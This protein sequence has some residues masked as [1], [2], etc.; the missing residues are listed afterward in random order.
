LITGRRLEDLLTV[1][2]QLDLFDCVVAENG[3]V[4][5]EPATRKETSLAKPAPPQFVQ[6]LK[7]LRVEPLEVGRVIVS[8]WL[9]HHTA[10]LQVIQEMR[11]RRRLCANWRAVDRLSRLG[12]LCPAGNWK[13][14][15]QVAGWHDCCVTRT[16][17]SILHHSRDAS[18]DD[19]CFPYG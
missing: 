15:V 14:T 9:P 7:E 5:Y 2:P 10:V 11:T 13:F 1:F 18:N 19:V 8:T 16:R 17:R 4:V 12:S 3:A 6:R